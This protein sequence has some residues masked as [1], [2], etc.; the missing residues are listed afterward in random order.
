MNPATDSELARRF[1]ESLERPVDLVFTRNRS[2]LV[3]WRVD[4]QGRLRLRLH[5]AFAVL[6]EGELETIADLVRAAPGARAAMGELIESRSA[7]L[8]EDLEDRAP[9]LDPVGRVHE[10]ASIRDDLLAEYFPRLE[11][12]PI[13]WSGRP[14]RARRRLRL[15]SWDSRLGIVRIHRCLDAAAVPRFFVA[16]VVHHELCHAALGEAP[17]VGGRRRHHGPKFR[18]L[19]RR[20]ADHHAALR[21]ESE[22]RALLFSSGR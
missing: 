7:A 2:R 11:P 9:K 4:A 14:G 20:F 3:T 19:E 5:R 22:H 12:P 1:E 8:R 15:G 6:A 17:V 16:S 21:W 10:L 13:G 18:A